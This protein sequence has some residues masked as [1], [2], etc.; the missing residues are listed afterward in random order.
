MTLFKKNVIIAF[1]KGDNMKAVIFDM[2]GVIVDSEAL[3]IKTKLQTLKE[4]NINCSRQ[5]CLPYFGRS[6]KA[7][8]S[9]FIKKSSSPIS[10]DQ[11]IAR[12]HQ[13]F[14]HY[15]NDSN[16]LQPIDGAIELI[17]HFK[18]QQVPLALASSS[19]RTNIEH[20]LQ[21]FGV[22]NYFDLIVS[23]AELPESKPNPQIYQLTAKKLGLAPS[24]CLVIEDAQSGVL[25]AKRAGCYCIAYANPAYKDCGQDLSTADIQVTSLRNI[26]VKD[27]LNY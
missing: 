18:V 25:A 7:F 13:L 22:F 11:I 26:A 24:E 8:F 20:C 4:Y 3:H 14:S 10:L 19:A 27:V 16:F 17:K 6:S 2:D 23:G 12:K 21:K 1:Y 15:A 5:E 9:D